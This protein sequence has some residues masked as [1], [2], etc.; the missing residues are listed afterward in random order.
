MLTHVLYF[1]S[2]YLNMR[3]GFDVFDKKEFLH[4]DIFISTKGIY[5]AMHGSLFRGTTVAWKMKNIRYD[6]DYYRNIIEHIY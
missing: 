6:I 3:K 2:P 1:P 4:E 5:F